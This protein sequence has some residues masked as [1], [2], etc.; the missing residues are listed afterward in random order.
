MLV[1]QLTSQSLFSGLVLSGISLLP[2]RYFECWAVLVCSDECSDEPPWE[3]AAI[4]TSYNILHYRLTSGQA[5]IALTEC[6]KLI[7]T[8]KSA[9][10]HSHIDTFQ[11]EIKMMAYLRCSKL[12][13]EE[14]KAGVR[15]NSF[16]YNFVKKVKI[17]HFMEF[18]IFLKMLQR[19]KK[20]KNDELK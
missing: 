1:V 12:M 18:W 11:T 17:K 3:E 16:F 14:N 9:V 20:I 15:W 8:N 7:N 6:D 10:R 5:D 19:K 13:I 2:E 4:K